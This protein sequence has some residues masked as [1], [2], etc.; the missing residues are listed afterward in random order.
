MKTPP[1][2]LDAGGL[3]IAL[4]VGR[5]NAFVTSKLLAGAKE[6][7][8][9]HGA[10]A[11]ELTEIW[12]P[13][14]WEL[15]LAAK[16]LAESGKYDGIV[17]LGCVIRGETTHHIHIG[18]EAARGLADIALQTGIPIG[19]GVLTTEM[20]QHAIDRAGG[21]AGNKGADTAL[22]VIEMVNLLREIRGR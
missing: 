14:A 22:A 4:L 8:L 17:C 18:G 1:E 7:L 19:F 9:K 6:T 15:P 2:K 21:S 11:G 5:F 10:T 20:V 13:G 16:A 12:T 3:R